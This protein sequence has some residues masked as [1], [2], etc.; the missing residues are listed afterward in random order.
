M[1]KTTD[2]FFAVKV[3]EHRDIAMAFPRLGFIE[4]ER[5]QGTQVQLGHGDPN[6]MEN[7]APQFLV[8]HLQEAGRGQYR[9]FPDQQLCRQFEQQRDL[10]SFACPGNGSRNVA[11]MLKKI[12]RYIIS[13]KSCA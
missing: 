1:A 13:L 5:L 12:G 11:V 9:H 8:G 2:L 3:D 6:I 10:A 4:T 7:D